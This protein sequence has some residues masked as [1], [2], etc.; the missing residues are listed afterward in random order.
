MSCKSP[1]PLSDEDI[2]FALDGEA[3]PD[4]L[5]HL[6]RCEEC[7]ARLEEARQVD[8]TLAGRLQRWDCP[9]P[10]QLGDYH[11]GFASAAQ[12]RTIARHLELCV[13]CSGEIED[14]RVF[15]AEP[16]ASARPAPGSVAR[17]APPKRLR[18]MVAQLL[19]RTPGLQMSA[20]RGAGDGPTIAQTPVATIILDTRE[21]EQRVQITG[22]IADEAGEQER[23]DGALVELRQAGALAGTAFVDE[24]G[25]FTCPP[26][27]AGETEVRITGEDSTWI[28]IEAVEL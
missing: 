23:W 5:A 7:S 1:P 28:I 4:V 20:V 9:T 21:V 18:A 6:E 24:V 2:S 22:Q 10:M 27:A 19:P 8:R 3:A 14:L 17:Q 25:G 16:E 11:L 15:V 26:V 13:R 12:Q